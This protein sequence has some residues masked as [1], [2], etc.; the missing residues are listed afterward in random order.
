MK[1]GLVQIRMRH[2][3]QVS[4]RRQEGCTRGCRMSRTVLD[5]SVDIDIGIGARAQIVC[6]GERSPVV[7]AGAGV[8]HPEDGSP[9]APFAFGLPSDRSATDAGGPSSGLADNPL[10]DIGI[11]TQM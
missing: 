7:S 5:V 11:A 2:T 10:E 6:R 3:G 1:R 9:A 4:K 8:A